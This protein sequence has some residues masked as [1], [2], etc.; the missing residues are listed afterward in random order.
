MWLIVMFD[1][2]VVTK[3]ERKLAS[4]FRFDLLDLGFE[5]SQYSVYLKFCASQSIASTHTRRI[6]AFMPPHGLVTILTFTD[7][8]IER[9][10]TFHGRQK[11]PPKNAPK[12]LEI[13]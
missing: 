9:A 2:P 10:I 5:M 4:G 12:Q 1:L 13:F 3:V 8:Q 11:I 7:K 6:Q